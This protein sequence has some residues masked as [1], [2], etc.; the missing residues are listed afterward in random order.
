MSD[1]HIA[2]LLLADPKVA[3]R[4][5]FIQGH[6]PDP[7]LV[8]RTSSYGH[9][10]FIGTDG[11]ADALPRLPRPTPL[12]DVSG[13]KGFRSLSPIKDRKAV[14]QPTAAEVYDLLVYGRFDYTRMARSLPDATYAITRS[15]RVAEAVALIERNRSVAVEG[16]L[17]NGKTLFLHLLA[18][19]LAARGYRCFMY[20]PGAPDVVREIDAMRTM[21]RVVI[22]FDLYSV[23][24]DAGLFNADRIAA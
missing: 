8:R 16:R 11:F 22:F 18:F 19:D 15:E 24:Q 23:A 9:T 14:T 10:L 13:L 6:N 4:T 5:F 21:E 12:A 20:R 7:I 17:G 3:A 1:Y 2:A